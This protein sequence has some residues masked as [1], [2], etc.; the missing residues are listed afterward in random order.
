M[1]IF[2]LDHSIKTCA[3]WRQYTL[4]GLAEHCVVLAL[5][6]SGPTSLCMSLNCVPIKRL[7]TYSGGAAYG[8]IEFE[9]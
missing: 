6:V 5:L 7:P 2:G 1:N 9:Q 4:N 3:Q 8:L